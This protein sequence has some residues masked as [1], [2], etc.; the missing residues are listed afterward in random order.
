L[1]RSHV[2]ADAK[3]QREWRANNPAAVRRHRGREKARLRAQRR[4]TE[5]FRDRYAELVAEEYAALERRGR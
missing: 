4:L 5:E 3:Y 2:D 1:S